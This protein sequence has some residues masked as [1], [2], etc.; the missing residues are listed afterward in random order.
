MYI[1]D[2]IVMSGSTDRTCGYRSE[3]AHACF[4]FTYGNWLW[5]EYINIS[6]IKIDFM[7]NFI[8]S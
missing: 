1:P 7:F 8:Q 6:D 3:N 2:F 5:S 4:T